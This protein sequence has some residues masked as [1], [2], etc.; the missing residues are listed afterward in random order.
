M[1][2]YVETVYG[3]FDSWCAYADMLNMCRDIIAAQANI[4]MFR[5]NQGDHIS[6]INDKLTIQ[7]NLQLIFMPV[8]QNCIRE[9]FPQR[10]LQCS[11]GKWYVRVWSE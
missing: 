3:S 10:L 2:C 7:V 9:V 1:V 8:Y 6:D 5:P 11:G 4:L